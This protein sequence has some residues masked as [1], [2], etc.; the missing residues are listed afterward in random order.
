MADLNEGKSQRVGV[1]ACPAVL[2]IAG[3]LHQAHTQMNLSAGL[4]A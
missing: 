4:V 1:N 3:L 2:R